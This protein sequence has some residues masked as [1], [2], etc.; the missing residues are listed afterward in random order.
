VSRSHHHI[1]SPSILLVDDEEF[2]LRSW[3][4]ILAAA[5]LEN[6]HPCSDS[7][8]VLEEIERLDA[9]LVVL[10][11]VLPHV[12]GEVLLGEIR[13]R[14]PDVPVIVVTGMGDVNLAVE[15]MKRG[16]FDYLQKPVEM[17]RFTTSVERGLEFREL[18]NENRV[19]K[20]RFLSRELEHPEA[21]SEIVTQDERMYSLFLYAEAIARSSQPVL[22]TGETGVGKELFAGALH[23]LSGRTGPFVAVNI[24]GFDESM[25]S[26]TLFGHR[27][28]A[29]TGAIQERKGLIE[30]ADQGTLF[31][32]EIGEL[33]T[34]SQIKLLRLL[35]VREYFPLGSD[36][37]RRSRARIALATN[38]YLAGMV[39]AGTFRRDLYYRLSTHSIEIPP[40]R[41]RKDDLPLLI[42][43]F[44]GQAAEELGKRPPTVPP[45]LYTLLETYEFPG[46]VRELG[47]LVFDAVSRH[48][49]G[50]LSLATFRER[51]GADR[52]QSADR[53]PG[54]LVSFGPALP[55]LTQVTEHLIE[56]AL[57]RAKG[58]QSIAASLLGLTQ[59]AL[60]KRLSRRKPGQ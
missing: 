18:S 31:L 59:Q 5:G 37:V 57:R 19:L 11:L 58:N 15:C 10:D 30:Q 60:S 43:H 54:E 9:D 25:F 16:A 17:D 24:A 29:F 52:A 2:V 50:V 8:K 35:D 12:R 28:G 47:S 38:R 20:S 55:T 46:N 23:Q 42:Q 39:S 26:D 53:P 21:F 36:S 4:A 22:I 6:T 32:D 3:M 41:E 7:R 33:D 34:A 1:V 49:S 44:I 48:R 40:L 51:I 13:T 14:F 56:E 45:Q 27:R